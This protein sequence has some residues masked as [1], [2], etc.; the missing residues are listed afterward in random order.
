MKIHALKSLSSSKVGIQERVDGIIEILETLSMNFLPHKVKLFVKNCDITT[1]QY[2]QRTLIGATN[3]LLG[4]RGEA[5]FGNMCIENYEVNP[6]W[7]GWIAR[8]HK[9][10]PE[11]DPAFSTYTSLDNKDGFADNSIPSAMPAAATYTSLDDKQ[12]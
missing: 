1:Q 4:F 11:P 9:I 12:D 8:Q 10:K 2:N 5:H 3:S 7:L 6:V